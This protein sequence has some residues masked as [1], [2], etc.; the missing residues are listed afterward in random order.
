[1]GPLEH[2]YDTLNTERIQLKFCKFVLGVHKSASNYA[3]RA[4]L[5][6]FPT[7]IYCLRSSISFWLHIVES[8]NNKLVSKA[9]NDSSQFIKGFGSN[10]KTVLNKLN[11]THVWDNQGTFSKSRLIN[12]ITLKLKESYTAFWKSK[13][14]DD[15]ENPINGN[16][17]RTY[18]K[19][20]TDYSIEKYLLSRDNSKEEISTF[21]KI[22]LSAHKLFIEEGRYKRGGN[23]RIP[24]MKEFVNY[25]R[26]M[27][28][29]KNILFL[30]AVNWNILE[31]ISFIVL[32]VSAHLLYICPELKG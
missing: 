3:A 18:R 13:L 1:M 9:Y 27:L 4:E 29:T 32:P 16:K 19:F 21:C 20:K 23:N 15:S 22:R 6:L 5:G 31:S 2:R 17:L 14:F 7:A 28:K 25:V 26:M 10:I 11:F 24:L 30:T 12:A 8:D